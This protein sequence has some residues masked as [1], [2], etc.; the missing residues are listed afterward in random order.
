MATAG[1]LPKVAGDIVYGGD[2]TVGQYNGIVYASD[3]GL[4]AYRSRTIILASDVAL[5]LTYTLYAGQYATNF[6][7][8]NWAINA[9]WNGSVPLSATINIY[10]VLGSTSKDLYAFDTGDYWTTTNNRSITI[11]VFS[12]GFITG[13]GGTPININN[14]EVGG[15]AMRF[16]T[17]IT[18]LNIS[19]TIQGGGGAGIG[20]G[21]AGY[22]VGV[23][24]SYNGHNST[25]GSLQSGGTGW[26]AFNTG[27]KGKGYYAGGGYGGGWVASG[28]PSTDGWGA[29][30]NNAYHGGS[31]PG[32]AI[33][34][35]YNIKSFRNFGTIRG[36]VA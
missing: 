12:G 15:P 8:R 1:Q 28:S 7:L 27:K 24:Y 30:R 31:A 21:G 11:N 26:G 34:G 29:G 36:R 6:N 14:V 17:S 22:Y 2:N 35:S 3:Y 9:G 16:A 13:K 32:A 23:G 25:N 5:N 20:G 33:I 18:L 4:P 19:G 10:G